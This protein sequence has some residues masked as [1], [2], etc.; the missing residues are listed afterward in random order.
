MGYVSGHS[1]SV[2]AKH[3][4]NVY[5]RLVAAKSTGMSMILAYERRGSVYFGDS[6]GLLS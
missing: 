5:L 6:P 4:L 3:L 2:T 1:G